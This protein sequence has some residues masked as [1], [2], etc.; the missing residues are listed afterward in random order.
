MDP[1]LAPQLAS[2]LVSRPA[3]GAATGMAIVCKRVRQNSS[4]SVILIG[5]E[6]T[7]KLHALVIV[8]L[9]MGQSTLTAVLLTLSTG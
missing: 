1:L 8:I 7:V 5:P 4:A 2:P 9:K 6:K 3:A